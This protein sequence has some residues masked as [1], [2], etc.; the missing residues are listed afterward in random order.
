MLL[1][2]LLVS[3]I[4]SKVV[5]TVGKVAGDVFDQA[6]R[7]IQHGSETLVQQFPSVVPKNL[8][9][10]GHTVNPVKLLGEGGFAFVYLVKD[11]KGTEYAMKQLVA[12]ED[13]VYEAIMREVNVMV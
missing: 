11:E 7:T 13:Q 8:D 12:H 2:L 5:N 9:I 1:L 4:F 3:N 6:G 10:E